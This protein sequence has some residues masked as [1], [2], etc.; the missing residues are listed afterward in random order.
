MRLFFFKE[1]PL[2]MRTNAE[3]LK[4]E[5]PLRIKDLCFAKQVTSFFQAESPA[6]GTPRNTSN[7]ERGVSETE[8]SA[9]NEVPEAG[10]SEDSAKNEE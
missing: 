2:R 3:S 7:T 10:D 6:S 5:T 1:T 4:Q 8:D 9:K